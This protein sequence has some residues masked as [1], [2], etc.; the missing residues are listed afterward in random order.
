MLLQR[1]LPSHRDR[2]VRREIM[3]VIF[4]YKK[5]ERRNQSVG[6]VAGSDINLAVS[7]RRSE[8]AQVHNPRRSREVQ[9]V[10]G[11]QAR[12]AVGPLHKLI[13]E[14]GPPMLLVP[15]RLRQRCQVQP[16]RV[17][18]SNFQREGVIETERS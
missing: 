7:E 4:K 5:I 6:G 8:Q 14:S 2:F 10:R 17:L 1:P 18:T 16:P 12:I 9:A 3:T 15:G 11:S 13:A